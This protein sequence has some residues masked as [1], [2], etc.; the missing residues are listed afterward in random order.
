ML[1]ETIGF[2]TLDQ[3]DG[4]VMLIL[5][6][7]SLQICPAFFQTRYLECEV[8]SAKTK[9]LGDIEHHKDVKS[10]WDYGLDASCSLATWIFALPV[11]FWLAKNAL[12]N[13]KSVSE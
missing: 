2:A 10:R 7:N 3:I 6:R 8:E 5:E 12:R 9:K 13:G 11:P 4:P 1:T